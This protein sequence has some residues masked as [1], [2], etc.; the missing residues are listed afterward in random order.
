LYETQPYSS[1]SGSSVIVDKVS[2]LTNLPHEEQLGIPASHTDM[3]RFACVNDLWFCAVVKR[4]ERASR[5]RGRHGGAVPDGW[6]H[7]G[8]WVR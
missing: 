2:A 1:R 4:I 5:G 6:P 8:G 7:Q 3:C